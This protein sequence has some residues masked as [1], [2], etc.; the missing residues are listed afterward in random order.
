M[1]LWTTKVINYLTGVNYL[2]EHQSKTFKVNFYKLFNYLLCNFVLC[3][4]TK[5]L[6]HTTDKSHNLGENV[7]LGGGLLSECF[8]SLS[9]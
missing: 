4:P 6:L 8:S 2:V 9:H 5:M 7:L 3:L 1:G